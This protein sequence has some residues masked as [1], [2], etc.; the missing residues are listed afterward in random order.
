[1]K[2][3]RVVALLAVLVPAAA[4]VRADAPAPA[5]A[6]A[7]RIVVEP[8][9]F[10][11][12]TVRAGGVVE[13]EFL[14]RNH[15][16]AELVIDSI[17]SSC[18]CTGALTESKTVKPGGSTPLRVTFTAPED[19]SGRLQKS[20]LIKSNDPVHPSLEVKIEATVAAAAK[21]TR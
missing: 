20:I 10:V 9:S 14:V 18:G 8:P 21:K 5:A 16:R 19:A 15:G 3:L 6:A 7:P 12:G 13:K 11:F 1:V 2:V 4:V 17:A